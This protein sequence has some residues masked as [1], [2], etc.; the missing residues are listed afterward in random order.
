MYDRHPVKAF[1]LFVFVFWLVSGGNPITYPFWFK[2]TFTLI[3]LGLVMRRR[4]PRVPLPSKVI[5]FL[6][7][8]GAFFPTGAMFLNYLV[9]AT[10]SPYAPHEFVGSYSIFA[11]QKAF[12]AVTVGLTYFE[13][14]WFEISQHYADD[15]DAV[16]VESWKHE[17]WWTDR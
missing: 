1:V 5:F 8:L 6:V 17:Y 7:F 2:V 11:I 3:Q 16:D 12:L 4:G 14:H 15:Y 13:D 9:M 10:S